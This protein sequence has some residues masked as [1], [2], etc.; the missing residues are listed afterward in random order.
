MRKI[1]LNCTKI[2]ISKKISTLNKNE[3]TFTPL[4]LLAFDYRNI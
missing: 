1:H 3:S 2:A 4:V